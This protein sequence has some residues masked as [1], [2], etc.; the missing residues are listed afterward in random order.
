MANGGVGKSIVYSGHDVCLCITHR[1]GKPSK[2]SVYET[3]T[4]VSL[5]DVA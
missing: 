1:I 4:F 2:K 5:N 3:F